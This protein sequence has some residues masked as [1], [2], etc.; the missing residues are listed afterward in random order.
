MPLFVAT[1]TAAMGLLAAAPR[2]MAQTADASSQTYASKDAEIAALK[3]QVDSLSKQVDMLTFTVS[4]LRQQAGLFEAPAPGA[5]PAN[6]HPE[7]DPKLKAALLTAYQTHVR[8][9]GTL[10]SVVGSGH[11]FWHVR[12]GD[13]TMTDERIMVKNS[14]VLIGRVYAMQQLQESAHFH[15]E[16]AAKSAPCVNRSNVKVIYVF[17]GLGAQFNFDSLEFPS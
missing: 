12:A 15:S 16:A 9:V 14:A 3:T 7:Q 4:R 2:A 8:S 5:F 11:D 10:D 13:T 17:V 1:I 6:S